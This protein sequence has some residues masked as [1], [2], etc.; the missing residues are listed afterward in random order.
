MSA[1]LPM[2]LLIKKTHQANEWGKTRMFLGASRGFATAVVNRINRC[3]S[4]CSWLLFGR[5]LLVWEQAAHDVGAAEAFVG[6]GR[7]RGEIL[8]IAQVVNAVVKAC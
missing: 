5:D 6:N 4:L 7:V 3:Y 8:K 2:E 1:P